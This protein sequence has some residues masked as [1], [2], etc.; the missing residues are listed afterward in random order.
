MRWPPTFRDLPVLETPRL[1][2]RRFGPGDAA[3]VFNLVSDL[4]VAKWTA[5]IPHPYERAMTDDWLRDTDRRMADGKG[6]A[7]AIE[8]RAAGE[9][10]GSA[11]LDFETAPGLAEI[12]YY[13]GRAHWGRGFMSE[14][15]EALLRFGFETLNLAAVRGEVMPDN[16]ASLSVLDKMGFDRL[17]RDEVDAPARGGRI[18]VEVRLLT[19]DTWR[20]RNG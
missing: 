7:F 1:R 13:L 11:G 9:L 2:L 12:G 10:I 6:I 20:E 14:A 16:A 15:A 19:A 4:A 5:R 3:A 8:T 18:P 17:G